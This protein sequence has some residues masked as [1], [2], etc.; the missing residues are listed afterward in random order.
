M[1]NFLNKKEKFTMW[2]PLHIFKDE[3]KSVLIQGRRNIGTGELEF[4]STVCEPDDTESK[5]TINGNFLDFKT[6][7]NKILGREPVKRVRKKV[8]P[9]IKKP[10]PTPNRN[11]SQTPPSGGSGVPILSLPSENSE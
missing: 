1:F 6:E 10:K 8:L 7:L 3:N 4:M 2:Q 9:E 5:T 11:L